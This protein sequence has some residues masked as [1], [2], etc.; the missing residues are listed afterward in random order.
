MTLDD[1]FKECEKEG[2]IPLSYRNHAETIRGSRTVE[3]ENPLYSDVKAQAARIAGV[4]A[5]GN[6]MLDSIISS[7]YGEDVVIHASD[8]YHHGRLSGYDGKSFM[9]D[10]YLFREKPVDV[11]KYAGDSIYKE[12]AAVPAENIISISKIPLKAEE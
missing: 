1:F 8:G 6:R 11:F 7:L 9:L 3:Y 2:G 10:K 4:K 12:S 5:A